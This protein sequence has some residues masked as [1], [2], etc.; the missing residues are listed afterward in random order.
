MAFLGVVRIKPE[1]RKLFA[2]R[3]MNRTTSEDIVQ[4]ALLMLES[5]YETPSLNILAGLT[6]PLF[7]SE[8][9]EYFYHTIKEL[10]WEFPE[11]ENCVRD[12]IRFLAEK[13]VNGNYKL[14]ALMEIVA[15]I[16][17]GVFC[18]GYP[19]DLRNWIYIDEG[20]N[21]DDYSDINGEK[22]KEIIIRE[23]KRVLMVE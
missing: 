23:A 3:Y 22:L 10:G 18:L 9:E 16:Y 19:N 13:I 7:S 8:V 17:S 4:W 1:T 14:N 12:Y 21:P 20:L 5:G 6:K 15:E 2:Y 11:G